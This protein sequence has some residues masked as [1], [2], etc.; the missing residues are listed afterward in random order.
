MAQQA[1]KAC[2]HASRQVVLLLKELQKGLL[3]TRRPVLGR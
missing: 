2:Q 1:H 3:R